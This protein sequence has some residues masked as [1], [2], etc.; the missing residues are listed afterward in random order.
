MDESIQAMYA[1]G[2]NA[3]HIREF[4]KVDILML[5]KISLVSESI[6]VGL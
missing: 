3:G 4:R 5:Y 6:H 1:Y 2:E